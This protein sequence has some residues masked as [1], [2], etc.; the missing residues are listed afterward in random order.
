MEAIGNKSHFLHQEHQ[1]AIWNSCF[2]L[3]DFNAIL[4]AVY[5]G[6]SLDVLVRHILSSILLLRF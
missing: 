1:H 3:F 6:K 4:N 5:Y 2:V